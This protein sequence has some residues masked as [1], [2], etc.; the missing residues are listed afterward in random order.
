[1]DALDCYLAVHR[2]HL[3]SAENRPVD[4]RP[5]SLH[6][7]RRPPARTTAEVA[8]DRRDAPWSIMAVPRPDAVAD[9]RAALVSVH[10]TV[11]SVAEGRRLVYTYVTVES[12]GE[13]MTSFAGVPEVA[14]AQPDSGGKKKTLRGLWDRLKRWFR[15]DPMVTRT[16]TRKRKLQVPHIRYS[17]TPKRK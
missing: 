4:I 1:M 11:G 13:T 17:K 10:R 5:L 9:H 15:K 14:T 2:E 8:A 3:R 12:D 6:I 7:R 16:E